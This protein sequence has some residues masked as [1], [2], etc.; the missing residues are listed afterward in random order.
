M[1]ALLL[2]RGGSLLTVRARVH[3]NNLLQ[4]L[5]FRVNKAKT[6]PMHSSE[7]V[8]PTRCCS[9]SATSSSASMTQEELRSSSMTEQLFGGLDTEP[10]VCVRPIFNFLTL[11][12]SHTGDS[13]PAGSPAKG[14]RDRHQRAKR[15]W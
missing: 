3:M 13:R 4:A 11:G 1:S 2:T 5:A 12:C 14:K 15:S 6:I 8:P 7:A 9:G 10:T